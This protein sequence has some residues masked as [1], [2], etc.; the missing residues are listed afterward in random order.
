MSGYKESCVENSSRW[1][2]LQKPKMTK[3][4]ESS[5]GNFFNI[6]RTINLQFSTILAF[7]RIIVQ[8]RNGFQ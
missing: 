4:Y 7:I 5:K 3:I 8:I 1:T 6:L 2:A